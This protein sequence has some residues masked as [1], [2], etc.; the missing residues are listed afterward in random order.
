MPCGQKIRMNKSDRIELKCKIGFLL[1][2]FKSKRMSESGGDAIFSLHTVKSRILTRL[3]R[4]TYRLFQ[5]AYEGD[6]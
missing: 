1:E 6:F 4:S 5:I 3:F 2:A